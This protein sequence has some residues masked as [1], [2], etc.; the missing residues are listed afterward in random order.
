MEAAGVEPASENLQF[1]PSTCVAF[2]RIPLSKPK[3]RRDSGSSDLVFVWGTPLATAF[4]RLS[5]NLTP[6]QIH[7]HDLQRRIHDGILVLKLRLGSESELNVIVGNCKFPAF[8]TRLLEPPTRRTNL[9]IP[10]ETVSPPTKT[11]EMPHKVA[12][13]IAQ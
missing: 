4:L 7:R 12:L 6:R 9:R 13:Y 2:V 3:G 1:R 10:V 8:L 5:C 11:A